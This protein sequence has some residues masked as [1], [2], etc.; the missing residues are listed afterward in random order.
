MSE[1]D[2]QTN[3]GRIATQTRVPPEESEDDAFVTRTR[4]A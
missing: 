1:A 4:D 2:E 3:T